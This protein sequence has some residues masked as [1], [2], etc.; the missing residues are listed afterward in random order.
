MFNPLKAA[1]N[2]STLQSGL[3]PVSTLKKSVSLDRVVS[4]NETL[5][6]ALEL[7]RANDVEAA[8][9]ISLSEYKKEF[10]SM[11]HYMT[12]NSS[13]GNE[14][15]SRPAFTF[16]SEIIASLGPRNSL[17]I[18]AIAEMQS[19]GE[20][21]TPM[22]PRLIRRH[23]GGYPVRLNNGKWTWQGPHWSRRNNRTWKTGYASDF[24]YGW[25]K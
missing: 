3:K 14:E 17:A 2:L 16:L 12:L 23:H 5:S 25:G 9:R 8:L 13:H 22:N 10:N 15:A 7:F 20:E 11:D 4:R 18:S 24:T 19:V 6:E 21:C 1:R